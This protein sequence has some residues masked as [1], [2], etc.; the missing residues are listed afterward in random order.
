MIAES[1]ILMFF[2]LY[3][4]SW[5]SGKNFYIFL[6]KAVTKAPKPAKEKKEVKEQKTEKEPKA[7]KEKKS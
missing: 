2:I 5:R 4:S 7:K 3:G 1:A 6:K